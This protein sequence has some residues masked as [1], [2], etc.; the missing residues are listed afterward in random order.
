MVKTC[1]KCGFIGEENLFING[2]NICKKCKGIYDR[3]RKGKS[4]KEIQEWLDYEDLKSKGIKICIRCG[5][6]G[7]KSLFSKKK[8]E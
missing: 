2:A 6:T 1:S 3:K 7:D 8:S 5:F 4:D